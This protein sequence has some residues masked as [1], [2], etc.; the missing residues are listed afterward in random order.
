MEWDLLCRPHEAGYC[1]W[2]AA[3]EAVTG[4]RRTLATGL[5]RHAARDARGHAPLLAAVEATARLP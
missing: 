4:G 5:L 1:R 3:Q 2:R